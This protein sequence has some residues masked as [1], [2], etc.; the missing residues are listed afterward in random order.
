MPLRETMTEL[1]LYV[2]ALTAWI[3]GWRLVWRVRR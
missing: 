1:A 3:M 2:P